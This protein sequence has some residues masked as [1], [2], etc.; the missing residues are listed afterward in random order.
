MA[1]VMLPT[2]ALDAIIGLVFCFCG[3][4]YPML[5]AAV[6]AARLS[7]WKTTC[8]AVSELVNQAK[9][10]AA[11]NKKDD[12]ADDDGDGV[13]DVN[14]IDAQALLLRK[15][16][17]VLTTSDPEKI[18]T[19]LGG[20]YT[21]WLGVVSVLKVQFAR[22]IALA[23]TIAELLKKPC[24][25]VILPA[26]HFV[27]PPEYHRWLP[28]V[29]AWACK[30]IG[31]SVAFYIQRIVSAF[32]SA[33]RG[34][35]QT[36][37]ALLRMAVKQGL[38]EGS[39]EDTYIDEVV[40][41]TLAALGFYFQFCLGFSVPWPLNWVLWPFELSEYY[42]MWAVTTPDAVP[43]VAAAAAAPKGGFGFLKFGK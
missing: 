10:I 27:V 33:V 24:D 26:L 25:L 40:G 8:D 35:L 9:I 16:K 37:R 13:K 18:N 11:E 32:S 43:D 30:S 1:Y 21:S 28:V 22:T 23:L 41:W 19:A 5:F 2:D 34:G 36:S 15:T 14:Q 7:G 39:D 12:D 31:M 20:L 3:G 6:Q 29:I 17:L 42:I 38:W 4:L